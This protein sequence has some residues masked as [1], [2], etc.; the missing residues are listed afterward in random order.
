M[1]LKT[2]IKANPDAGIPISLTQ[3]YRQVAGVTITAA[4]D[5]VNLA[6]HGLVDG[7]RFIFEGTTAPAPAAKDTD[8]YVAGTVAAGTFMVSPWREYHAINPLHNGGLGSSAFYFTP[9]Q[10]ADLATD[11]RIQFSA[12]T[13][14]TGLSASTIYFAIGVDHTAGSFQVSLTSGG[15]A[16]DLTDNGVAVRFRK[17][18]NFTTAG[19]AVTLTTPPK[20]IQVRFAKFINKKA[21]RVANT[22]IVYLGTSPTNDTQPWEFAAGATYTEKDLYANDGEFFDLK[23][24]YLDVVTVND[25]ITVLYF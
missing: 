17:I 20:S 12:E 10:N 18:F 9:G 6:S 11:D 13:I 8:Y 25:A 5:V 22:G 3:T 19:T 7:D 15:A 4:T 23:D 14:P 1:N 21:S 2:L 16:V 24:L